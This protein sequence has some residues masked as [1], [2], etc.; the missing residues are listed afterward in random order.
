M[1]TGV[2]ILLR[3]IRDEFWIPKGRRAVRKVISACVKCKKVEQQSILLTK[4][5]K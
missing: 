2:S 4:A 1:K 5:V 3:I